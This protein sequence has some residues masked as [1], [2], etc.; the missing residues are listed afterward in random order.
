MACN[1]FVLLLAIF[2]LLCLAG[3]T[4]PTTSDKLLI[5]GEGTLISQLVMTDLSSAYDQTTPSSDLTLIP[6]L[7]DQANGN[8]INQTLDYAVT[9]LFIGDPD[10]LVRQPTTITLL[11]TST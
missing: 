4:T 8:L 1:I 11:S 9:E 2:P 10:I 7:G 6:T 5:N 3:K